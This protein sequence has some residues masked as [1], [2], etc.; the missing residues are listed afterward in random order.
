MGCRSADATNARRMCSS[1]R[2]LAADLREEVRFLLVW[3]ALHAYEEPT[4]RPSARMKRIN[5][6]RRT[7]TDSTN[8][9]TTA[10]ERNIII[11]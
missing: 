11:R 10:H 8:A 9:E 5:E 6:K 3:G 4:P 2:D 7:A 1:L